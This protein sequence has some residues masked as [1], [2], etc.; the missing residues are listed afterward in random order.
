MTLASLLGGEGIHSAAQGFGKKSTEAGMPVVLNL[1][2]FA[3]RDDFEPPANRSLTVTALFAS[4]WSTL[5]A[6]K[7]RCAT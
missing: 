1:C 7:P 6:A 2:L 3:R 5:F 4:R